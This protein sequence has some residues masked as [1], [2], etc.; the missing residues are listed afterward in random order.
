MAALNEKVGPSSTTGP[1]IGTWGAGSPLVVRAGHVSGTT[2]AFGDFVVNFQT[3]FPSGVIS[4]QVTP[5]GDLSG[6]ALVFGWWP[7]IQAASLSGL[8]VYAL[9]PQGW[10]GANGHPPNKAT[11]WTLQQQPIAFDYLVLGV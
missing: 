8:T 10:P 4:V 5:G 11:T 6:N 1:Y 2:S 9:V 7:F 3:P